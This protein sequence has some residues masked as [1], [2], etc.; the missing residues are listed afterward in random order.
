MNK[1]YKKCI[2]CGIKIYLYSKARCRSCES[3]RRWKNKEYKQKNKKKATG[4]NFPKCIDCG[5]KIT[6]RAKRCRK[7]AGKQQSLKIM[8]KKNPMYI[9]GLS[10]NGYPS[11]FNYK[12]KLKIFIRDNFTCQKCRKKRKIYLTAHHIDYNKQNCKKKNL[13]TLCQ[14][15]NIKVNYDRDYWYAYFKYIM[16]EVNK[17]D[18]I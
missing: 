15:C 4:R 3:K 11:E 8:G 13:I 9:N 2:D 1:K 7:C 16:K 17:I 12:L 10:K 14:R 18:G 6:Y 5:K